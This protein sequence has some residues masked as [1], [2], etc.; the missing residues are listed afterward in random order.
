MGGIKKKGD[1]LKLDKK[2][3][4][5]I[6]AY[7]YGKDRN[8]LINYLQNKISCKISLNL[9]GILKKLIKDIQRDNN[10]KL[11]L[12]SP[13]AASFDQFKNFEERGKLFFIIFQLIVKNI[14]K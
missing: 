10:E 6:K 7:I 12:F 2:Y 3:F 4:P 5:N 8:F 9:K 13:A 14:R 1:T 11:I